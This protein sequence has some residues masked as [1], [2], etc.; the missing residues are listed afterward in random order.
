MIQLNNKYSTAWIFIFPARRVHK[1]H[2]DY[3]FHEK[4]IGFKKKKRVPYSPTIYD[5][6]H[7]SIIMIFSLRS[8][9]RPFTSPDVTREICKA[10]TRG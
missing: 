4:K 10:R 2:H 8:H 6:A 9:Q 3:E 1:R 5:A 7:S